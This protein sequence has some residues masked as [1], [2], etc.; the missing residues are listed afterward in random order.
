MT[1]DNYEC[2][3]QM[4]IFDLE[5]PKECHHCE[6]R[7]FLNKDGKRVQSCDRYDGCEFTPNLLSIDFESFAKKYCKH[8]GAYMSFGEE[9]KSYPAC[10]YKGE[11]EARSWAD[12]QKCNEQNCPFFNFGGEL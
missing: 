3:G 5:Q 12:W 2:D 6:Y 4:S 10:S 1:F 7:V 9:G 8:Q 11:Q